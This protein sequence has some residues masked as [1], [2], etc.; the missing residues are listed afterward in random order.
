LQYWWNAP[1]NYS[2]NINRFYHPTFGYRAPKIIIPQYYIMV[3][4]LVVLVWMVDPIDGNCVTRTQLR[5][6]RVTHT[7]F[8]SISFIMSSGLPAH[9][10]EANEWP[11]NDRNGRTANQSCSNGGHGG[12]S[13]VRRGRRNTDRD[14]MARHPDGMGSDKSGDMASLT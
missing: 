10:Q 14:A 11:K 13:I 9:W 6:L 8:L 7:I 5:L 4:H 3:H 1:S 2:N 12:I